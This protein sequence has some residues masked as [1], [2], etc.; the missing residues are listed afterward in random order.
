MHSQVKSRIALEKEILSM[1]VADALAQGYKITIDNGGDEDSPFMADF[2]TVMAE[3][4]HTDQEA[5]HFY[6]AQD[7]YRGSVILVYGNDGFDVI[8]DYSNNA[9]TCRI[10]TRAEAFALAYS[11]AA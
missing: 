2:E 6:D 8:H 5:L 9:E 11:E 1:I 7:V 10:L 4:M 3:T